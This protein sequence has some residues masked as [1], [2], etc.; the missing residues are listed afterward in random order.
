MVLYY[1]EWDKNSMKL[2]EYA[3]NEWVLQ[4]GDEILHVASSWDLPH[5]FVAFRVTQVPCLVRSERGRI[6]KEDYFPRVHDFF[7]S[8]LLVR[9]NQG[10]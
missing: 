8:R 5:S 4:K 6:L 10:S 2:L 9:K 7:S 3:R 1:S